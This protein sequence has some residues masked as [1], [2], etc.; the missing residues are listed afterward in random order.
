MSETDLTAGDLETKILLKLYE[1]TTSTPGTNRSEAFPTANI[2]NAMNETYEEVFNDGKKQ[3]NLRRGELEFTTLPDG[4]V[5]TALALGDTSIV[6]D[7]TGT[8][9]I[10]WPATGRILIDNELIDYTANDLVNTL[11][12]G[13]SELKTPHIAGSLIRPLYAL[14][15]DI[16][17]ERHQLFNMRGI[18]HD[19]VDF[20]EMLDSFKS[21]YR[22]YS[23]YDGFIILQQNSSALGAMLIYTIKTVRATVA[24]DKFSL[25][26]NNFRVPLIV[27]GSVGKLKLEDGQD[28]YTT[29][30]RPPQNKRDKGGG[31][32]FHNLRKFYANY[33]RQG[34]Q[35]N[36]KVSAS[37]WD[38]NRQ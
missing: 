20:G 19:P 13:G 34:D 12:I 28:D 7:G 24:A 25:I 3:K 22:E 23:V 21:N 16:D 8:P 11:T 1:P 5:K 9:T 38:T 36:K 14:P 6:F 26:P 2:F 37:I 17:N 31:L 33:G 32:F 4:N 10:L 35:R 15:S 18:P 29:Y 30:Y 27:N